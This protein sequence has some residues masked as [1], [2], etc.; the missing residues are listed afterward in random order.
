MTATAKFAQAHL[1]P[2]LACLVQGNFAVGWA[3]FELFCCSKMLHVPVTFER[4]D[5]NNRFSYS[6]DF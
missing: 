1:N 6:Q 4:F 3:R 2:G 5:L